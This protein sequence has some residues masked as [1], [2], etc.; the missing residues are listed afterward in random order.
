VDV[1]I[2]IHR[3]L[4]GE[5]SYAD[6]WATQ[7]TRCG[8]KVKWVN[9][10]APDAIEQ[11]RGCSG[12]MWRFR[13]ASVEKEIA[14][15]VLTAIQFYLRIPVFPDFNTAWHYD[16]KLAQHYIFRSLGIP[17]P[18][19]WVFWDYDEAMRWAAATEYPKVFKTS[20]GA[21]SVNVVKVTCRE[22]AEVLVERSFG[23]RS[24]VSEGSDILKRCYRWFHAAGS[25]IYSNLTKPPKPPFV[26]AGV[27]WSD[28]YG[29]DGR[30]PRSYAYFQEFVPGNEYDTRITVIGERAFGFRRYNRPDDFRASGSGKLV[31]DPFLVDLKCVREAFSISA[32]LNCQ[33]MAYDFIYQDGRPVVTEISYTYLDHA[34]WQCEGHW[35]PELRWVSGHMWPEE[36][37]V[38]DFLELVRQR[39]SEKD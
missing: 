19:T 15:R 16:D 18:K 28:F 17:T 29:L 8:A 30:R 4:S 37:Q 11:V 9:L 7:L 31:Y 1:K 21:G 14:R 24:P 26:A 27:H 33:S 2:A 32:K 6:K 38:E 12:V 23:R 5:G 20:H 25:R 3:D 10:K 22:E 35:T 39:L 34:V 36:A 13:H